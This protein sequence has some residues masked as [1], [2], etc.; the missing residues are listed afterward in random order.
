[1]LNERIIKNWTIQNST[2]DNLVAEVIYGAWA[3]HLHLKFVDLAAEGVIR[4]RKALPSMH[5][6][7]FPSAAP[8]LF[9]IS[10]SHFT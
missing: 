4:L 7:P 8:P 5:R 1:M 3:E 6:L 9:L 10:F 2:I